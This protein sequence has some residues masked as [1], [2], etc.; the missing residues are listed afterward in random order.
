MNPSNGK[1]HQ[2]VLHAFLLT[3]SRALAVTWRFLLLL[4][5]LP[6]DG[7]VLVITMFARWSTPVKKKRV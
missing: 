3:L 2:T 4:K 5:Y 7:V 6:V 1:Y